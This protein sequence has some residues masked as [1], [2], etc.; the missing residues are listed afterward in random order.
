MNYHVVA[1]LFLFLVHTTPAFADSPYRV[2]AKKGP[3]FLCDERVVEDRWL[4]DRFV[5]PLKKHSSNPLVAKDHDWE[6]TGPLMDG[7]VLYDPSD[8]KYKMWYGVWNSHNYFNQLPFSYNICYA[9]SNDGIEWMKPALGVFEH[10]ADPRNNYIKLGTDKTQ[11][12]D[13]CFNPRPDKYPG[14]F[15]AIHDEVFANLREAKAPEW[16]A[17]L[18]RRHG[19]EAGLTDS[20]TRDLVDRIIRTGAEYEKTDERYEHGI[21]STPTMIIN[22]RMIIGTLPYD[23]LRAIFQALLD[24]AEGEGGFLES[25]E[26]S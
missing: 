1:M 26:R 23:Q 9:E 11:A 19:V 12:I 14:K 8:S 4:V 6:G 25:W 13:V 10:K 20:Q 22:G 21:R 3:Y 15:L 7:S 18:A 24:Q 17:D 16:R 5:V 2:E